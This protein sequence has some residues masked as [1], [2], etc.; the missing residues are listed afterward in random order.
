ML[1]NSPLSKNRALY[2]VGGVGEFGRIHSGFYYVSFFF[3]I[4][5]MKQGGMVRTAHP[6][7]IIAPGPIPLIAHFK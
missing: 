7:R 3:Y 2:L 1:E 5:H 4:L 6:V